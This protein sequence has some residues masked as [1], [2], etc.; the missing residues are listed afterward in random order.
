MYKKKERLN[1]VVLKDMYIFFKGDGPMLY[2]IDILTGN[3]RVCHIVH[4]SFR[5]WQAKD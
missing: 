2:R 3:P 5:C 1:Q 4:H